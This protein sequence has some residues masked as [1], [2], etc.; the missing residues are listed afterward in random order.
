MGECPVNRRILRSRVFPHANHPLLGVID[1]A[2]ELADDVFVRVI[3]CLEIGATYVAVTKCKLDVHLRFR[4]LAFR[5][6]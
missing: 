1:H 5:I 4:S 3:D 6:A 2:H